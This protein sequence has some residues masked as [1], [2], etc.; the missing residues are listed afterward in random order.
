MNP[1][2]WNDET[3]KELQQ[4]VRDRDERIKE[5]ER[6]LAVAT[7]FRTPTGDVVPSHGGTWIFLPE[8][9]QDGRWFATQQ[10]ALDAA[11]TAAEEKQ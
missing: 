11:L 4:A 6:R 1:D 8:G 10:K 7:R 2:P 9:E 3:I 5:L